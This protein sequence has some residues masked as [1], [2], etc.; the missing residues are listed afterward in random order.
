MVRATVRARVRVRVRVRAPRPNPSPNPNPNASLR[1]RR[2]DERG[3]GE[4]GAVGERL[5]EGVRHRAVQRH[6][7]HVAR[8]RVGRAVEAAEE[9]VAAR[10]DAAVGPLRAA[11]PELVQLDVGADGRAEARGV[12]REEGGVVDAGKE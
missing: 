2:A 11:Q 8:Q 4:V 3:G 7:A 10:R 6:L 5:D 9:G 1:G 12:G